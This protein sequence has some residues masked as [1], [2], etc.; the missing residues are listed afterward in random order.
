MS[1][2]IMLDCDADREFP[3]TDSC[4]NLAPNRGVVQ[5]VQAFSNLFLTPYTEHFSNGLHS[6]HSIRIQTRHLVR[7]GVH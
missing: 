4:V 3:T 1:M 6:L 7:G 2:P 5:A